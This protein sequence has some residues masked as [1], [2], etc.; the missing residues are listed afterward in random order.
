[1]SLFGR[2]LCHFA[3]TRWSTNQRTMNERWTKDRPAVDPRRKNT[4]CKCTFWKFHENV[5]HTWSRSGRVVVRYNTRTH[6]QKSSHFSAILTAFSRAKIRQ[7]W[8]NNEARMSP[9]PNP[10]IL[11]AKNLWRVSNDCRS[12]LGAKHAPYTTPT[13]LLYNAPWMLREKTAKNE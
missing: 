5:S 12:T 6:R 13:H 4:I 9:L 7:R 10:A 2:F 8:S 1:M 11:A 3:S